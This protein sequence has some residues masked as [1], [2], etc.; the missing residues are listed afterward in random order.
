MDTLAC[1]KCQPC[2]ARMGKSRQ[3][4]VSSS[5]TLLGEGNDFERWLLL[6]KEIISEANLPLSI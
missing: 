1:E 2:T 3:L 4:A 5:P 6:F